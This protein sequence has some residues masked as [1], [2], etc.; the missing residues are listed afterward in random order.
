M[1]SFVM[2]KELAMRLEQSEADFL[3]SRMK[4]VQKLENNP[5]G[6]EIQHFNQAIAF[7]IRKIPTVVLFLSSVN[8]VMCLTPKDVDKVDEILS[9]YQGNNMRCRFDISPFY[10]NEDLLHHLS[11][12]GFY[13]SRFH[14]ALYGIPRTDYLSPSGVTVRELPSDD[15]TFLSLH[16]NLAFERHGIPEEEREFW[17]KATKAEFANNNWRCYVAFVDGVAAGDA[18]LY[19]HNGIGSLAGAATLSKFRGRGCQTALLHQRIA[20]AAAAKCDL[21]V[22]QAAPGSISQRNIERAGLRIA[23]IKAIWKKP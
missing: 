22:S 4:N 12:R 11:D 15:D 7:L 21:V 6:V 13:Q 17:K 23:Y 18:L 1:S 5:L 3:L 14:T 19:I 9:W 2:T 20:D 10:Y 8:R 16:V